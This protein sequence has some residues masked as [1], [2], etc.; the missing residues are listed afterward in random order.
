MSPSVKKK[1][2][3]KTRPWINVHRS[4]PRY[5]FCIDKKKKKRDIEFTIYD[6]LST[7]DKNS[8]I[9]LNSSNKFIFRRDVRCSGVSEMI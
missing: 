3:K 9:K 2:K 5:L 4:S 1:K 8:L 7:I 6:D